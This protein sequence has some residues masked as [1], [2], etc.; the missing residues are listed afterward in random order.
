MSKI[1]SA[2]IDSIR[3]KEQATAPSTPASGY[4][5]LYAKSDGLY[6]KG[7]NGTEIGPFGGGSGGV[8][9]ALTDWT[10]VITQSGTVAHTKTYAKYVTKG[11]N[12]IKAWANLGIT[13]SGTANNAIVI[14]GLPET[15]AANGCYGAVWIN[16]SGVGYYYGALLYIGSWQ[17]RAHLELG[18]IGVDPNFGLANGDAILLEVEYP[19]A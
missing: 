18:S 17:V 1:S 7:D 2:E 16:D 13:G 3:L 9:G 14:S 6:F 4:G 10:P 12:I 19:Y 15:P 5:Q 8:I 11:T